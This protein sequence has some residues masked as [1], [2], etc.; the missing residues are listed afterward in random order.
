M[1][2]LHAEPDMAL[3]G[4]PLRRRSDASRIDVMEKKSCVRHQSTKE[5]ALPAN[6]RFSDT[7]ERPSRAV[8]VRRCLIGGTCLYGVVGLF[9]A[10]EA[11]RNGRDLLPP[12]RP[13]RLVEPD[14]LLLDT[15]HRTIH[16]Q[17]DG[18]DLRHGR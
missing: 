8:N 16:G 6:K 1:R 5:R 10:M 15:A 14:V 7:E 12:R 11:N 3:P 2:W 9:D 17:P 13:G 18:M 4:G